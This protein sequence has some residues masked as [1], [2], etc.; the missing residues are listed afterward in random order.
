MGQS[1][2]GLAAT[3]DL[4]A[5]MPFEVLR[6]L[7]RLACAQR[8][9]QSEVWQSVVIFV[10]I[11]GIGPAAAMRLYRAGEVGLQDHTMRAT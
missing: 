3:M 6:G 9:K 8:L 7:L 11:W 4:C 1:A 10:Q 5:G 2:K